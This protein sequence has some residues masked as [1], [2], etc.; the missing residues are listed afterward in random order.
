MNT[1]ISGPY[2]EIARPI[3]AHTGG[4]RRSRPGRGRSRNSRNTGRSPA[5]L[6]DQMIVSNTNPSKPSHAAGVERDSGWKSPGMCAH[7]LN[8]RMN[9]CCCKPLGC[10]GTCGPRKAPEISSGRSTGM[11]PRPLIISTII[12]C[13]EDPYTRIHGGCGH[14]SA[15]HLRCRRTKDRRDRTY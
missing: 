1:P 8:L 14:G 2:P 10:R 9:I 5:P 4:T 6:V 15:V 12:I 11:R 7:A 3:P 13:L